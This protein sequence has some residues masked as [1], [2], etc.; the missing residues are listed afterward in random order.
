MQLS[1]NQSEYSDCDKA[2]SVRTTFVEDDVLVMLY[3][4]DGAEMEQWP[5][6]YVGGRDGGHS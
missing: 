6:N 1:Y 3:D 2:G 5:W 4:Q